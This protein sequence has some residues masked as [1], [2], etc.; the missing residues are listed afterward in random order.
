MLILMLVI[1]LSACTSSKLADSYK[2]KDVIARAK[3]VVNVI[4]TLDYN[5]MNAEMRGDLQNQLTADSLKSALDKTLTKAGTFKEYKS[6]V[7]A[8]QKSKSTGEDYA[9]VILTCTYQN[10]THIF[11]INM[12]ANLDIVGM[13]L[14]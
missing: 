8:G 9:T 2:E 1:T 11:T 13:Y 14:K 7:T 6:I 3:E 10:S 5:A 4:N 12:D